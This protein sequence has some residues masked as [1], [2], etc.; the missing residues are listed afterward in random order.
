MS[1]ENKPLSQRKSY[2]NDKQKEKVFDLEQ[3]D[4][5]TKPN[6]IGSQKGDN[7][8]I[9]KICDQSFNRKTMVGDLIYWE[10]NKNSK[11]NISNGAKDSMNLTH[12]T[13]SSGYAPLP[14]NFK[15]IPA[16]IE[17]LTKK[18][19][20]LRKANANLARGRSESRHQIPVIADSTPQ[21]RRGSSERPWSVKDYKFGR[22]I[23]KGAYATVK[24]VTDK[25]NNEIMA[26][27]IYEKFRLTDPARRK[28]VVREIAIMKRL[29]HEN[30]VKMNT[31]FDNPHSIHIVM[32]YVKGKSLYQYLKEKP[33]K[34]MPEDEA[35][36]ITKQIASWIRYIHSL[37]IAHRD[38]KL[39]NII[40]NSSNRKITLI[41]FG[42]SI[43]C[44]HEKKLKIFWGTP[45]YMWPEIVDKREYNGPPVDIWAL[46]VLLYVMLWG[47]F[48]FRG[49]NERD[50]YK[51]ISSGRYYWPSDVHAS[52][53]AL[54]LVK[55]MLWTH[56]KKR[57]TIQQVLDSPW[58]KVGQ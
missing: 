57:V 29:N 21:P 25:S 5:L 20:L 23:G 22:Q 16:M 27:K 43:I 35:R 45:S 28:S 15:R 7:S 50:L 51:K 39:E 8:L 54:N 55:S 9:N 46:G 24:L 14:K 32:E 56:P 47:K 48:P 33:N 2:V 34:R 17:S 6:K 37:D 3:A 49:I 12:T 4:Y 36:H 26:M 19:E 10:D 42:F 11:L 18:E 44:G 41:D 52:D 30:I 40:I 31:S 1:Q 38:L 58:F 53:Q 13:I